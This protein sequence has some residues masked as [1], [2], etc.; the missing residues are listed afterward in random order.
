[1]FV[2][3]CSLYM[4][5]FG[6]YNLLSKIGKKILQYFKYMSDMINFSHAE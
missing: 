6:V 2:A 4:K 1:M 5:T 3:K